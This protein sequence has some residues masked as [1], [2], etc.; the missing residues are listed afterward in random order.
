M[1]HNIVEH[2]QHSNGPSVPSY[3][4]QLPREISVLLTAWVSLH[5]YVRKILLREMPKIL[6]SVF[7]SSIFMA[8]GL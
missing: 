4:S 5:R 1:K 3:I 6:L 2:T 7:S 8:S